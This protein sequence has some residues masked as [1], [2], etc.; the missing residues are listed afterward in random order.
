[1]YLSRNFSLDVTMI[2]KRY[3]IDVHH[4]GRS[5]ISQTSSTLFD[6]VCCVLDLPPTVV[7]SRMNDSL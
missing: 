6:R 2:R 3:L 7:F 4:S 5:K 1:M